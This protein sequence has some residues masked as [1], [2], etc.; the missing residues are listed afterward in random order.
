M[1]SLKIVIPIIIV[2]IL[3][4]AGVYAVYKTQTAQE[5]TPGTAQDSF[6]S[7]SPAVSLNPSVQGTKNPPSNQPSTGPEDEI[8]VNNIGI[9]ISTPQNQSTI[10]SPVIVSGRAN[11]TSQLV[12]I[13]IFD[14][15][16]N[17]L[18][19]GQA[20]ACVAL[21]ACP[22]SASVPF[23]TPSTQSGTIEVYSPSMLEGSKTFL[24]SILVSFQQ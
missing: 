5:T 2:A 10:T 13:T 23:K 3:I 9:Q 16:G 22:F 7:A 21:D 18:G 14:S 1:N 12:K 17:I 8:G 4:S 19:E 6:P 15:N 11:V 24:Q 20:T